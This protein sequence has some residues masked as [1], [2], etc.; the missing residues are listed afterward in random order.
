MYYIYSIPC[1]SSSF[2]HGFRLQCRA[3]SGAEPVAEHLHGDGIQ[4]AQHATDHDLTGALRQA[5][6]QQRD[7]GAQAQHQQQHRRAREGFLRTSGHVCL[8]GAVAV[9]EGQLGVAKPAFALIFL[10]LQF[11]LADLLSRRAQGL[12]GY[13]YFPMLLPVF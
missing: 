4:Q 13:P 2:E 6:H 9:F 12:N 3:G 8:A 1:N 10:E 5:L 7:L 11:D